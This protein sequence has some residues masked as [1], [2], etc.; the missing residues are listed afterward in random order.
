MSEARRCRCPVC[1]WVGFR[2]QA[3]RADTGRHY[4]FCSDCGAQVARVFT[5]EERRAERALVEM[6]GSLEPVMLP[7][8]R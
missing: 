7:S 1:G 4:G 2:A 5:H 8:R 6:A 3:E